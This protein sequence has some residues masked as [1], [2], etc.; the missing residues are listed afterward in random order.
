M[1][2]CTD[3]DAA[4]VVVLLARV[5]A[6]A[7]RCIHVQTSS[8]PMARHAITSNVITGMN[9]P[10]RSLERLGGRQTGAGEDGGAVAVT[11]ETVP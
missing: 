2:V 5:E 1:L 11:S 6:D 9:H 7:L 8:V 3:G 10:G 4:G